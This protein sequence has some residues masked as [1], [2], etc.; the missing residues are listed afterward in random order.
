MQKVSKQ[1]L[2]MLALSILLAISIALT[3]TFAAAGDSKSATG[4][5]T[6]DSSLA[7]TFY[8]DEGESSAESA[9]FNV[10]VADGLATISNW[11]VAKIGFASTSTPGKITASIGTG[12]GNGANG[13]VTP[14]LVDSPVQTGQAGDSYTME[15]FIK[16][17]DVD[18]TKYV[19]GEATN[20]IVI[21]FTISENA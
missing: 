4:T 6:F 3:F 9:T 17:I 15:D 18:M 20:N 5:I 2:A 16:Q 12:A 8:D 10:T 1:S 11:S 14:V 13:C 21:T 19:A 7:I